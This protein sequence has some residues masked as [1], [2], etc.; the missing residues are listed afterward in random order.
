VKI[1]KTELSNPITCAM[2]NF[3][4]DQTVPKSDIVSSVVSVLR[5]EEYQPDDGIRYVVLIL[6][7]TINGKLHFVFHL[8]AKSNDIGFL[9]GKKN[10]K[11]ISES[12]VM[13]ET[14][15]SAMRREA[16]EESGCMLSEDLTELG[17]THV[18]MLDCF[19]SHKSI[20]FLA[21]TTVDNAFD[22]NAWRTK[23]DPA[24]T[25][26]VVAIP[27]NTIL[28]W[29]IP[30]DEILNSGVEIYLKWGENESRKMRKCSASTFR[31]LQNLIRKSI[32]M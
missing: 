11:R 22:L 29:H 31:R 8:N 20:T 7:T 13:Y 23:C 30:S 1:E 24:E 12:V 4:S 15:G 5:D 2:G 26:G 3:Q 18:R 25:A 14:N 19:R 27:W 16:Y 9:A 21:K 10:E 17:T 6:G 32:F 28:T